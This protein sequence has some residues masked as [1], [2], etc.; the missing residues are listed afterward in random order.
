VKWEVSRKSWGVERI[1]MRGDVTESEWEHSSGRPYWTKITGLTTTRC[2][3]ILEHSFAFNIYCKILTS[4]DHLGCLVGRGVKQLPKRRHNSEDLLNRQT[5]D[6]PH[7][8]EP[9]HR[10]RYPTPNLRHEH[11]AR[12]L[13]A[14]KTDQQAAPYQYRTATPLNRKCYANVRPALATPTQRRSTANA[15]Q[16]FALPASTK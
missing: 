9:L 13:V 12:Y 16:A 3:R 14:T 7:H 8:S 1:E 2:S 15:T 6:Q 10:E 5:S 4:N 11:H